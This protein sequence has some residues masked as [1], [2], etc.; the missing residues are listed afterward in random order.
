MLYSRASGVMSFD[1]E[2]GLLTLFDS[3]SNGHNTFMAE[4]VE[5]TYPY[6]EVVKGEELRLL[7]IDRFKDPV[8]SSA[9]NTLV[10]PGDSPISLS[11]NNLFENRAIRFSKYGEI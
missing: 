11:Y 4:I 10:Y 8:A 7:V 5:Y 9:S 1:K 6:P 2:G 3:L